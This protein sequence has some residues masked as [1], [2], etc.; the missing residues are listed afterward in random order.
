MTLLTLTQIHTYTRPKA[1]HIAHEEQ[2]LLHAEEI[3]FQ[4]EK[5]THNRKEY[6]LKKKV[7]NKSI[8]YISLY[9]N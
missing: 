9:Y 5:E 1:A 2:C 6:R 8:L 7:I 3:T 4:Q